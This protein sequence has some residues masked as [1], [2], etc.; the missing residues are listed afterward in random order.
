MVRNAQGCRVSRTAVAM[1]SLVLMGATGVARAQCEG[2]ETA[3]LTADDGAGNDW[4]GWAVSLSGDTAL[5]GARH[6]DYYRG[7]AYIFRETGGVWSQVAK[8]TA[9]NGAEY[10]YFGI[11]VCLSGDT[12]LIGASGSSAPLDGGSA[13]VFRETD[14]VWS[15]VAKLTADDAALGDGFGV[16]VSLSGA[17]AL[18]G[19]PGDGFDSGS[20]Y[21]FRETGGVWQQVAKVTAAD[22]AVDDYFGGSVF[23]SGDT[24]LIGAHGDDD[25]GTNGGSAYVFEVVCE[26]DDCD[27]DANGDGVVDPLDSG[28]V[29]SRFGCPVG[30]GDPNC[31]IADQNGDG[32]VDPLDVGYVL[33]RFGP[34]E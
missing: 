23:L 16:S 5:I 22:G 7:S 11:S 28:F 31:D 12:A 25:N 18:I 20:A 29:L 13:Y 6:D 1:G 32:L 21:V 33:A 14:G 4:F 15:Q 17:T 8:L 26:S 2:S 34:C 10:D 27:G 30:T 3:K 19:A 9:A 24:A